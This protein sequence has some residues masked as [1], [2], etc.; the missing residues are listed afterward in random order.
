MA[1]IYVYIYIHIE[2]YYLMFILQILSESIDELYCCWHKNPKQP[3]GMDIKRVVNN[4]MNKLPTAIDFQAGFLNHQRYHVIF[5]CYIESVIFEV[6]NLSSLK[7]SWNLKI[8]PEHEKEDHLNQTHPSLGLNMLFFG[9][10][11]KYGHTYI[12]VPKHKELDPLPHSIQI[13]D[14]WIFTLHTCDMCCH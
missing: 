2:S 12:K 7:L 5:L 9:V 14:G 13:I 10:Y 6:Y 8:S 4:G 1:Y 3:S 11:A